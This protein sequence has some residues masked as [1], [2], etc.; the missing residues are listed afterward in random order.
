MAG[1]LSRLQGRFILSINDMPEMRRIFKGFRIRPVPVT[2]TVARHS[3]AAKSAKE[4]IISAQDDRRL[5][6]AGSRSL[7]IGLRLPSHM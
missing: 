7:D 4:L 3:G 1:V 5:I 6:L 2:D